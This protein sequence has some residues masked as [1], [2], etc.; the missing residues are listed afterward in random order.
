M[1]KCI[2]LCCIFFVYRVWETQKWTCEKWT[3]LASKCQ[4]RWWVWIS[5][6]VQH[7]IIA[8][9]LC[10]YL[11]KSRSNELKAQLQKRRKY[12]AYHNCFFSTSKQKSTLFYVSNFLTEIDCTSQSLP[13]QKFVFL[14]FTLCYKD[15]F[16][17]FFV[18]IA[19]IFIGCMLE[20][21]WKISGIF[22]VRE[23]KSLLS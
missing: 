16:H 7:R 11:K 12:F 21:G 3:N 2:F 1:W 15:T 20:S 6:K 10:D 13:F 8:K 17:V 9:S 23:E 22:C 14:H 18:L 4:V 19:F 5:A